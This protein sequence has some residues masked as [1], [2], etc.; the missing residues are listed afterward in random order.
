MEKMAI[1]NF[2]PQ[3]IHIKKGSYPHFVEK[4]WITL[5]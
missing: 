4:M 5:P 1:K 3:V 2:N